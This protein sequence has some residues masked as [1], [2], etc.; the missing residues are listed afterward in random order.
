MMKVSLNRQRCELVAGVKFG[1]DGRPLKSCTMLITGP[2]MFVQD[3]HDRMP[4]LLQPEQIDGWL[5]GE[6][7]KEALAPAREGVLQ[8]WPVSRR[9]NSSRADSDDHTLISEVGLP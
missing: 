2:N 8:A 3:Y 4:V 6:I 7:G 9:V 5:S 1:E